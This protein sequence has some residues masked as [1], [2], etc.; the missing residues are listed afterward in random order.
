MAGSTT[1]AA[2]RSAYGNVDNFQ[3]NFIMSALEGT[4]E[5]AGKSEAYRAGA[6]SYS[7]H[8][9]VPALMAIA[10]IET[11][12]ATANWDLAYAY[13][14]GS[15]PAASRVASRRPQ[16]R[17]FSSKQRRSL[18]AASRR[19]STRSTSTSAPW[20]CCRAALARSTTS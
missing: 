13:F 2:S 9:A 3:H 18:A 19:S 1:W 10:S 16:F 14:H 8:F 6:A 11:S 20:A 12:G 7:M 4:G 5:F 17:S 15:T